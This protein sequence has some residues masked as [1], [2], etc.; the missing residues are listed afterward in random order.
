MI[1]SAW[2]LLKKL[3]ELLREEAGGGME[4]DKHW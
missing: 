1:D 4:V 3:L 2:L